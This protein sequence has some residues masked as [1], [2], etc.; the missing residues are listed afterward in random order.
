MCESDIDRL[1]RM[2]D[3]MKPE[4]LNDE[5][6]VNLVAEVLRGME[7]A[8]TAA[9]RRAAYSPSEDNL[10]HLKLMRELYQ[11]DWFTTMTLG[12]V[13]GRQVAE[14]IIRRALRGQKI[15]SPKE[16]AEYEAVRIHHQVRRRP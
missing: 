8:L 15:N 12:A 11:T 4:D 7:E 10:R 13:D 6:V 1:P 9:A 2:K 16:G 3:Y 14:T 5:G